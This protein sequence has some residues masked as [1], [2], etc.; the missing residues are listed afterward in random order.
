MRRIY[1]WYRRTY[2]ASRWQA[3][4]A[5]VELRKADWLQYIM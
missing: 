5:A 4:R 2:S 1:I 3:L